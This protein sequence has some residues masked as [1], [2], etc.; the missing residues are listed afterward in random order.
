ML[1]F[2]CFTIVF[3]LRV[4]FAEHPLREAHLQVL[5]N[6]QNRK[7][8]IEQQAGWSNKSWTLVLNEIFSKLSSPEVLER[9]RLT[10]VPLHDSDLKACREDAIVFFD[11]CLEICAQRAWSMA[12]LSETQPHSWLGLCDPDLQSASACFDKIR[13]DAKVVTTAFQKMKEDGANCDA[14]AG[15]LFL[16][17]FI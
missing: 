9:L 2:I 14:Q 4:Y 10:Q 11:L 6:T 5:H 15:R 7:A 12:S 17:W 8:N 13:R 3:I 1:C 16:C